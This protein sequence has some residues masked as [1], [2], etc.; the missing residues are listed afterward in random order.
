MPPKGQPTDSNTHPT[1]SA[2]NR[3]QAD[4]LPTS[5][6]R[7]LTRAEAARQGLVARTGTTSPALAPR[8]A[9][10]PTVTADAAGQTAPA[11]Q[12]AGAPTVPFPTTTTSRDAATGKVFAASR[13]YISGAKRERTSPRSLENPRAHAPSVRG[14]PENSTDRRSS[15]H[16]AALMSSG[17][18]R[19]TAGSPAVPGS[20]PSAEMRP[21]AQTTQTAPSA[22]TGV[23][24][25]G[26]PYA[27]D[28]FFD[29]ERRPDLANIMNKYL[30]TRERTTFTSPRLSPRAPALPAPVSTRIVSP[31]HHRQPTGVV[32]PLALPPRATP[33]ISI[34]ELTARPS[35]VLGSATARRPLTPRSMQRA[36]ETEQAA[37]R[38]QRAKQL[39]E[40][41]QP[42]RDDLHRRIADL[43]E[44][45]DRQAADFLCTMATSQTHAR[46]I[47]DGLAQYENV[48]SELSN[49]ISGSSSSGVTTMSVTQTNIE[50]PQVV[51]HEPLAPPEIEDDLYE[52]K[53][54]MYPPLSCSVKSPA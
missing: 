19:P 42:A 40:Q 53:E 51:T 41:L 14:E 25:L 11:R 26:H 7:V 9:A 20:F 47:G 37:A 34:P 4:P 21:I 1:A 30:E 48:M 52:V 33:D 32:S 38:T 6:G 23:L 5:G 54:L 35:P 31:I 15:P 22:R 50:A 24:P 27:G 43:N 39:F 3:G 12:A 44:R 36:S 13:D 18:R 17:D 28:V 8:S 16:A 45:L 46:K 49:I 10:S 2:R 29:R